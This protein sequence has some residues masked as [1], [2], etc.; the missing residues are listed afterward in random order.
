MRW[1][2]SRSDHLSGHGTGYGTG[3]ASDG[4]Q[5]R[6]PDRSGEVLF[7]LAAV[8]LGGLWWIADA[9]LHLRP[10]QCLEALLDLLVAAGGG[11][12][13]LRE[14]AARVREEGWPHPA[15]RTSA[16]RDAR[17][18]DAAR[19]EGA[20]L[21]GYTVRRE[22]WLWP[23]EARMKHGILVGGTGAGKS[24][25][26]ENIIA[27]DAARRFGARRMPMIIFD[28]K[29]EREFLLRMLPHI[30]A[31][32]R[33]RDV[34]VIDPSNPAESAG[35][36]PFHASGDAL[37]EHVNFVFRSFGLREDFFRGHQEAYLTDL[38]RILSYSGRRFSIYDVLVMALDPGVLAEQI[39]EARERVRAEPQIPLQRRLNLEMSAGMLERSL[40]DRER[41]EKIQG[42]LNDLVTFLED[43][44]SIVTGSA[45]NVLTL[46][47]VLERELILFVSL[48]ANRNQR[49]VEALGRIL[50]QNIQLMVG[51]RYGAVSAGGEPMVSVILDEF[52]PFAYPGFTQV[53]QT[54]R[55]ARI[56]FLFSLQS[57][58]QLRRVS[59][60]FADEVASAPGTRIIM[61]VTEE[62]TVQWFL[63]ASASF[64]AVRRSMA[65]RRTGVLFPR[66][67]ETGRGT[68]SET[69]QTRA[70]E[71]HIKNLPVGQMQILMADAR[72]GNR[73][74]HLHA[75][76]APRFELPG[77]GSSLYPRLRSYLDTATAVNL[78]FRRGTV[79]GLRGGEG[80]PRGRSRPAEER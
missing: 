72:E 32:G 13:A 69:R 76:R 10:A 49:A 2:Q 21:L 61:N 42:L 51:R 8:V 55:G 3:H 31:A 30:E 14:L 29:G 58:P 26:L 17:F 28:G 9:C 74:A 47:E 68:Q 66:Y 37:Q 27:Q 20:T 44:L 5:D 33:L 22:P 25:L 41:I 67:E 75:R 16:R 38:V 56:A 63:R 62:N 18:L 77:L 45:Q 52:A 64:P 78:R 60:P 53:L 35:Y 59:Q 79:R 11:A 80:A 1:V 39:A 65:V 46:D 15:L 23:D 43:Q 40:A 48:N 36:N 7:L 24:T 71:E 70:R 6:G 4:S 34:R 57:L 50:L 73:Y 19:R 12:L 54:A